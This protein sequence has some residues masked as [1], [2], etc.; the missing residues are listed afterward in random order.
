MVSEGSS[1]VD[2]SE[3]T[4]IDFHSRKIGLTHDKLLDEA[5]K[6][7]GAYNMNGLDGDLTLFGDLRL[8]S[9]DIVRIHAPRSTQKDG[10]YLVE[11]VIT[12][13]DTNG[14]RQTINLPYCIRRDA[15]SNE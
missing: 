13:F 11:K 6:F 7:Y 1:R 14:F 4:V 10:E 8:D 12:R 9:G 3:Y 2:L 5:I 15:D